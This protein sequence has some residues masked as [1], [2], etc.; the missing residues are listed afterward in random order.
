MNTENPIRSDRRICAVLNHKGGVSK[1][2]TVANMS[3]LLAKKGYNV[4]LVDLDA[5]AN[6][7]SNFIKPEEQ[8]PE[9]Y[10]HEGFLHPER[11]ISIY[12]IKEN[13]YILPSSLR[14]AD[15]EPGI[16]SKIEREKILKRLLDKIISLN[17]FDIIMLDC[18][19]SLGQIADN[20]LTAAQVLIIPITAEA[21]PLMGLMM[22]EE[23]IDIIRQ[24]PNPTLKVDRILITRFNKQANLNKDIAKHINEHYADRVFST[25]IRSSIRVPDAQLKCQT[26]FDYA[27]TCTAAVDYT[28][29]TNEFLDYLTEKE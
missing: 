24:G 23:K 27:P 29:V 9:W 8:Q 1:T 6:L 3:D 21:F 2:T 12:S 10:I 4:L 7:T 13:L 28:A 5:Q 15:V 14:T 18:P 19:P 22:L 20:A 26:I 16:I 25:K 17:I 11:K